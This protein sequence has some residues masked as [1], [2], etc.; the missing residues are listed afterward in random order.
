MKRIKLLYVV[1]HLSTGGMPQFVLER[2]KALLNHKDKFEVYILE[3]SQF[4]YTYV[5]QRNQLIELLDGDGHFITLGGTNEEERK[6][7]LVDFIK[8]REIDIVHSEEMLEGFESFNHIPLDLLNKI[9]DKDRTWRMVETCHNI[10]FDP[11]HS[12]KFHP[13]AY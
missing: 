10:W 7:R 9:Y 13:E 5:V 8:E 4:S 3:Y 2:V 1:P 12:K 11:N 6:Y